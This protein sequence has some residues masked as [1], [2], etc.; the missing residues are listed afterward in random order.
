MTLRRLF[1]QLRRAS[2]A[3]YRAMLLVLLTVVYVTVI[4]WYALALRIRRKRVA[5]WH[6]RSDPDLGTLPRLRSP[7]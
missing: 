7:Y 2:D 6:S 3:V 1:G 5:G 4:P